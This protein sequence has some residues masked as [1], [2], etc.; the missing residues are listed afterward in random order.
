[1]AL[2]LVPEEWESRVGWSTNALPLEEGEYLVGWH[3]ISD[4]DQTYRNGL[5]LVNEEG[6]VQAIS[7]YLL[8]PNGLNESYCDRP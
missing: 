8:A 4:G 2:V 1:M 6:Y 3:G 5:A 7:G